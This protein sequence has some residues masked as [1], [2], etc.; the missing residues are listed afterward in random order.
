M[1]KDFTQWRDEIESYLQT[2]KSFFQINQRISNNII[3]QLEQ[4][5][6]NNYSTEFRKCSSCGGWD[7]I[8]TRK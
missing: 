8:I 2:H 7:I 1:T 6:S 3:K 5:F 4:Y